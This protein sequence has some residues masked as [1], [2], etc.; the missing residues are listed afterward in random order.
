[1]AVVT[2]I[3]LGWPARGASSSLE[4]VVRVTVTAALARERGVVVVTAIKYWGISWPKRLVAWLD[5]SSGC[6][7]YS[8]SAY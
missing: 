4:E 6:N 3:S 2:V 1:V 5:G 7:C 8:S